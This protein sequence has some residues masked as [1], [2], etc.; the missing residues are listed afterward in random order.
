MATISDSELLLLSK[1]DQEKLK[2]FEDGAQLVKRSRVSIKRLQVR[3]AN[4]RLKLARLQLRDAEAASKMAPQLAR[5]AVSR[6]Y[7][8]MYH[9][10]R[11]ATYLSFGGDD[12]EKHSILP[13]K[14]PADFPNS[15]VWK[16]KLKN[17]RLERNRADYDPY[18]LGDMSFL[19]V[20]PVLISE[21]KELIRITKQYLVTKS[22]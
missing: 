16:N 14:L 17:A 6:A 9:A 12:H 18:P 3:V 2:N 21:A 15:D 5:T 1:S 10:A 22:V 4:D 7:Y 13:T 8:A 19:A 20:H 11:A